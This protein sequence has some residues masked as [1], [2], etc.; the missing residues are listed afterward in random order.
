MPINHFLIVYDLHEQRLV[1]FTPFENDVVRATE[2]YAEM[3]R[4]FRDRPD[5]ENFEIVL[6][7][8]DSRETLERTHSRYFTKAEK[9]PF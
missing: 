1:D 6:V 8:A 2:A 7:G 9:V 5:R 3:E 4:E